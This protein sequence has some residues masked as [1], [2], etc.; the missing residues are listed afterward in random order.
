M[1]E[2]ELADD[3][4]ADGVEDDV[5]QRVVAQRVAERGVGR[6]GGH[7]DAQH[8]QR[9]RDGEHG[10]GEALDP[11]ARQQQLL[12]VDRA[13]TGLGSRWSSWSFTAAA[14]VSPRSSAR[15]VTASAR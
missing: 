2:P 10:V 3:R 12:V 11:A 5:G 9:G 8:E 14:R 7:G 6:G 4:E 13:V 15:V 1:S